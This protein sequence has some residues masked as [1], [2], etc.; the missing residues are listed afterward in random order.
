MSPE[1]GPARPNHWIV[2]VGK[3]ASR[4]DECLDAGIVVIGWDK[5]GDLEQY[6]SLPDVRKALEQKYGMDRPTNIALACWQFCQEMEVGDHLFVKGRQAKR[7]LAHGVVRSPYRFESSRSDYRHVREVDWDRQSVGEKELSFEPPVKTLTRYH[8]SP[9]KVE[10]LL[11][12]FGPGSPDPIRSSYTIGEA[13]TDLFVERDA[14]DRMLGL[15]RRK[16]NLVLS[17]APG[18]GKT[19]L[20]KRLAWLLNERKSDDRILTVQFHQSYGYEDFVQGYRPTDSGGF[21]LQNGPFLDFCHEAGK[22]P[23]R[24]FVLLIDEINRGNLSRIF[25]ELLML[26]EGDKRSAEWATRLSYSPATAEPFHVPR[27][28]YLIGTMNTADRSLALVDYALRRRF[29]FERVTPAFGLESFGNHLVE[30]GIPGTLVEQIVNRLESLNA[31]IAEDPKLG[32]GFQIGHSFFC[33]PDK[34]DPESWYR[35]VIRHEIEPLLDEY[36][37]DSPEKTKGEADRLA[38]PLLPDAR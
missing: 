3:N 32:R 19:Y 25:G 27:N 22:H 6:E 17:G 10:E 38:A 21:K 16:R 2:S 12:L 7:V 34:A 4:W 24:T 15:W 9:E 11:R 31:T 5:L 1:S 37:F 14:L 35:S 8:N 18:T 36:W 28:L 23:D 13:L 26:I 33:D 20:A 30:R 29:A